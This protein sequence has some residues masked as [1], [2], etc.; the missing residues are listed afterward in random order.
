VE[1][2]LF[3][4]VARPSCGEVF[5]NL[6]RFAI[7]DRARIGGE[8]LAAEHRADGARGFNEKS[9]ACFGMGVRRRGWGGGFFWLTGNVQKS[10][11]LATG[12]QGRHD[13]PSRRE[14]VVAAFYKYYSQSVLRL[15]LPAKP[16]GLR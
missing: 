2:L 4:L 11:L 5:N 13:A 3:R 14:E 15:H 9:G 7:R 10:I 12:L 6:L 1:I 8:R 16:G